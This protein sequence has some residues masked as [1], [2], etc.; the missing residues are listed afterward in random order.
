LE[1]RIKA[2]A[3]DLDVDNHRWLCV[4]VKERLRI[5]CIAGK[6]GEADFL[7]F[8][9]EP[10]SPQQAK[11]EVETATILALR[12]GDLKEYD[13]IVLANVPQFSPE[14]ARRL[15]AYLDHGG[16]LIFFLGDQVVADAYD[17]QLGAAGSDA[18]RWWPVKLGEVAAPGKFTIDPLDYRHRIAAP[19]QGQ[20]SAG[21]LSTP[22]QRYM[23]MSVVGNSTNVAL[24]IR[25]NGDPLLVEAAARKGRVVVVATSGSM[26]SVDSATRQ[27]WTYWPL[28]PSFLPV[29]QE[30]LRV[31]VSG[32]G[33][34][35]TTLVGQPIGGSLTGALP[36]LAVAVTT[37]PP[38]SRTERVRATVTGDETRWTFDETDRAGRYQVILGPPLEQT[39]AYAVNIDPAESDLTRAETTELP[40]ELSVAVDQ[41]AG[42]DFAA[43]GR[44]SRSRLYASLLY[45]VLGLLL[46]ESALAWWFGYRSA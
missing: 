26:A 17:R 23:R 37:P 3:S 24:A 42:A 41:L 34:Q 32:R 44:P 19:F 22:I 1:L 35:R 16:G 36:Q 45:I 7:P 30:M 6:P 8:A 33:Q 12:G 10:E 21:L 38:Q 20:E 39:D 18:A 13:A 40:A 25:E 28:W 29:M 15:T 9:F 43:T 46:C 27:P 4:P 14:E 2:D 11:I 31:A 5:L